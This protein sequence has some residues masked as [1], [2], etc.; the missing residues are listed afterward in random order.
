MLVGRKTMLYASPLP[1][2]PSGISDYSAVLVRELSKDYDITLYIEDYDVEDPWL[3]RLPKLRYGIDRVDW[4]SF[5]YCVYNMG[6]HSGFHSYIYETALQHPG[7]VI[8][9]DISL[10][11]FLRGYYSD[12]GQLYSKVFQV[13]GAACLQELKEALKSGEIA[14]RGTRLALEYPLNRELIESGNKI[15]VHSEFGRRMVLS[16]GRIAPEQV[17]KISQIAP[18]LDGE[19]PSGSKRVLRGK[20]GIPQDALMIASFGTIL[21]K[22]LNRE[23]ATAVKNLAREGGR[24]LCYVMVGEGHYVDDLLER[25][26]VIKTGFTPLDEFNGMIDCADIVAN[27]RNPSHGE[28]SA[29]MLRILQKGKPCITND[30]GWFTEIPDD[31]V[32]KVALENVENNIERALRELI[33]NAGKREE[34]G[35]NAM[36]YVRDNC[37]PEKIRREIG[38]FLAGNQALT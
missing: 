17:R 28:T 7:M 24:K 8:L 27:M 26:L 5:D 10:F 29:A 14:Q 19:A 2:V 34:L 4:D 38:R 35:K 23:I 36:R 18:I 21:D 3:R 9:H 30:G 11:D 22:K 31:C 15:M 6:N 1:P 32:C 12:R 33:R 37:A 13:G 25:D 16:G 20:Y